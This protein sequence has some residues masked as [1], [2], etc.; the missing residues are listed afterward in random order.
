MLIDI[1]WFS[2]IGADRVSA[3]DPTGEPVSDVVL[4]FADDTEF[5]V[6]QWAGRVVKC[7]RVQVIEQ[8][9]PAEAVAPII[10]VKY[11]RQDATKPSLY[12]RFNKLAVSCVELEVDNDLYTRRQKPAGRSGRRRQV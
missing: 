12:Q 5:S 10:A 3:D 9:S 11:F 2:G 8:D 4:W 6:R 1:Q 7:T